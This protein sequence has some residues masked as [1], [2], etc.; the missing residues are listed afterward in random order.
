MED[1]SL[2]ILDIVENSIRAEASIIK[3]EI[4]EDTRENI[5]MI[6][7]TDN[8][9]GMDE[10]MRSRINDPFFTTKTCRTVGLGIPFLAQAAK[11]CNGDLQIETRQGEGS[12]ITAVFQHDHIDR[13][14]LGSMEKTMIVLIAANPDIDFML[15]HKKNEHSYTLDTADIKKNLE[16]I[17]INHPSVIKIIKND[18]SAWL[19]QA[20]NV[21][22]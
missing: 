19:N 9:K 8:G 5:F 18:I 3:I 4:T 12:S 15:I 11:E 6:R 1:L 7:I 20:N 10:E 21:I 14:P 13:K 2:H 17:P 16:G 22:Q